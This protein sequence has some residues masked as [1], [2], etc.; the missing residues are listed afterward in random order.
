MSNVQGNV[1]V[2][3]RN[4]STLKEARTAKRLFVADLWKKPNVI[5]VGVGQ[6][7]VRGNKI[8][9][10]A[11][12]VT[13]TN[14][15]S[16]VSLADGEMV[17]ACLVIDRGVQ[18]LTDVEEGTECRALGDDAVFDPKGRIRPVRGGISIGHKDITAGTLG[19]ILWSN[20]FQQ[21]VILS[22]NHVLANSNKASIGD[23]IMQPG[24]YDGGNIPD[25]VI[26]SLLDFQS[27]GFTISDCPIGS[28]VAKAF[29]AGA[30][31]FGRKT[32]LLPVSTDT[33][34]MDAAIAS[35]EFVEFSRI[36]EK[37]GI[38]TGMKEALPTMK[39]RKYG[40]TTEYTEG[41]VDQIDV[42]V[43]VNYGNAGIAVFEDQIST[44]AMSAGG[45]SGSAVFDYHSN[46]LVGLLFAGSE[47]STILNPIRPVLERFDL[48]F[49]QPVLC[50]DILDECILRLQMA[51]LSIV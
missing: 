3:R 10:W 6:K 33:N 14:K 1:Q 50:L 19:C 15:V 47:T 18:V 46:S 26:G 30:M 32:R 42:T 29:N 13:V 37:I 39:V 40:R 20:R 41:E 48:Q 5:S 36:V 25:D 22:N 7:K 34:I 24:S 38:P 31:L 8:G 9:E 51:G 16:E 21:S 43:S 23:A 4:M 35:I 17:P 44:T 49:T 2:I 45:D 12:I 27:I 28:V 11:V